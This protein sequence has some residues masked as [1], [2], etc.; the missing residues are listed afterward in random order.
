M[1]EKYGRNHRNV[2]VLKLSTVMHILYFSKDCVAISMLLPFD[3]LPPTARHLDGVRRKAS[4]WI[5]QR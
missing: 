2:S 4:E 1:S 5:Y 3:F